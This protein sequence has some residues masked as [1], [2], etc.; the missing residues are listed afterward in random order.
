MCPLTRAE[1]RVFVETA[2]HELLTL[3]RSIDR[4]HDGRVNRAEL[5]RAFLQTGLSVPKRRLNGFFDE[6]DANHDGYISFEEWR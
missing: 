5:H 1:F 4:D 6:M 2:E 3:F